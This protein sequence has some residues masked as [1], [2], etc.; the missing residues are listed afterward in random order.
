MRVPLEFIHFYVK[1]P[2]TAKKVFRSSVL[3]RKGHPLRGQALCKGLKFV[4]HNMGVMCIKI[5]RI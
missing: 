5:R 2:K 1:V 3:L 4:F